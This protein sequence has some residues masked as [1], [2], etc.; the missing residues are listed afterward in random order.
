MRAVKG[1]D[2]QEKAARTRARML[3]AAYEAFCEQGYRATTMQSI[4]DRAGVAVQTMYYS[5]RTKDS[6]LQEV[7]DRTVLGEEGLPPQR[8]PWHSAALARPDVESAVA[9]LVAGIG[10]VLARVAPMLPVFHSVSADPA[11]AVFR[12]GEQLRREGCAELVTHLAGKAPLRPGL[13][14][15]HACDL[16]VVLLG[17]ELYRALVV[18]RGWPQAQW[19]HW[20]ATAVLR[21]L[22]DR[23][24]PDG[25]PA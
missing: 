25:R 11:G 5:F 2:R 24:P 15:E 4:A 6:L 1:G 23:S 16:M 9:G 3:D 12:R 22:F 21:D 19:A 14:H 8:Q 20:V 13:P 17:P 18:E 7:H 10:T